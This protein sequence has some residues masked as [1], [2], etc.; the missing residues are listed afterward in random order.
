MG[1]ADKRISEDKARGVEDSNLIA[2]VEHA[3][4]VAADYGIVD[5]GSVSGE[6]FE[7]GNGVASLLLGEQKTVTVRNRE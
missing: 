1:V 7:Y 4:L 3:T 6:I 5:E 2:F